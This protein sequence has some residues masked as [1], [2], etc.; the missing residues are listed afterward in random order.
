MSSSIKLILL[1]VPAL[2]AAVLRL[3][4]VEPDALLPGAEAVAKGVNLDRS[5][6][7]KLFLTAGGNDIEPE[8]KEQTA[9][10]I[11][12]AVPANAAR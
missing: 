6:V 4:A 1:L 11:T 2:S 3:T 9:E 7:D 8:I 10:S 12:F 5:N